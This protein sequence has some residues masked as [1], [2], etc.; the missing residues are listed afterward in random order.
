MTSTTRCMRP[1]VVGTALVALWL[2]S[3]GLSCRSMPA[4]TSAASWS[5]QAAA[6]YLDKREAWWM[7]W[8]PAARDHETFCVSCHTVL[9]YALG[10]PALSKELN[11]KYPPAIDVEL[12][13]DVRKRVQGWKEAEPYYTDQGS[14]PHKAAE[15]RGTESVL[16]ALILSSSDARNGQLGTDTRA[17]LAHM[18]ELQQTEGPDRGSWPWLQFDNE[19]F[20]GRGSQYYG[21]ALAAVATGLAPADCRSSPE[22]Q[23]SIRLLREYLDREYRNQSTINRVTLLWASLEL[24]G[25]VPKRRQ[26]AIMKDVLSLQRPDGGW[27]LANLSWS[28]KE[29]S[30]KSLIK[31]WVRSNDSPLEPKSD[32]YATGLIAYTFEEAGFPADDAHLGK[33]LNWLQHAQDTEQ[34]YWPGYSLNK[35]VNP[36]S[37]MG[38]FMNDAATGFAVLALTRN[39]Q[40]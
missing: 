31:L 23:K 13:A 3:L 34:G 28:W 38:R 35:H 11:E 12:L 1:G 20:E 8:P 10:R 2:T 9:P 15:S 14:G 19:P 33:A 27:S 40:R 16:N 30:T 29:W 4:A 21:A 22:I 6:A 25:L 26:E 24:P 5:P 32:G 37:G 7:K 18:W 17:A 36:A 39:N